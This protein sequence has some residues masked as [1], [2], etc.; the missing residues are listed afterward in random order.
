MKTSLGYLQ[1]YNA[2]AL[3]AEGQIVIAAELTNQA[4]D[5][6]LLR[7]LID[8]AAANLAAAGVRRRPR[9][10]VADA[11]YLSAANLARR[12]GDPELLVAT[13]SARRRDDA[14]AAAS[15]A[16]TTAPAI[17][18]ASMQRA[19]ATGRGRYLYRQR[20]RLVEPVFGQIKA[21]RGITDLTRRGLEA[22][23]AEWKL[24]ALTHNLL[25]LWRS[26]RAGRV[27]G[28]PLAA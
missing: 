14:P 6:P 19:L 18:I 9:T 16:A 5:R 4:S 22:C 1:G 12:A 15:A 27:L 13:A 8:A 3:V 26:G 24:I 10:L 17:A 21:A 25:K 28:G 2:Q 11:G 7:P 23:A 20:S